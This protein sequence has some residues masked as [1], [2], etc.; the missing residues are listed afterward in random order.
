M[1]QL[2]SAKQ[3]TITPEIKAVVKAEGLEPETVR[4]RIAAGRAVIPAN[5]NR[6]AAGL[7]GIGEGLRTKVNANI[8][9]SVDFADLG[10]ELEKLRAAEEAGA[11]AV[12]D[13]STGGDLTAI[14]R[15]I[16]E[17]SSVSV[18]TVPIYEATCAVMRRSHRL[19]EM[20]AAEVLGT[21]RKHAEDGVDFVVAHAAINREVV[22]EYRSSKR[23]CGIVSRGGTFLAQ[24]MI[25]TGEENPLYERYDDLLDMA[26]EYDVTLSLGDSMR[27][28]AIADA[29]DSLQ[30]HELMIQGEL[31][32]RALD[33]GVQVMIEGPGHV[34]LNQVKAQME[35]EKALCHG[36][37]F[38]VLGPVVT[39]V[40]IGYDHITAAIGGAVAA[41]SGADFLCYVTP[42]E[43]VGLPSP[44]QV[45]EG[46]I[47]AR[48]AAHAG[49]I[50]KGI[51]GAQ[52]WDRR[53][54]ELRRGRKW[55]EQIK[56]SMDPKRAARLREEAAPH[57]ES[58]CS[59]CGEYCV[60]KMA[61]LGAQIP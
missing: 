41:A 55:A 45:R 12:M 32:K 19:K 58:V 47:A 10:V 22:R 20:T 57:D 5:V 61:D 6:R 51:P 44:E 26:R 3:G 48:I 40:A 59:M 37:P 27:P 50:A 8:G 25:Q 18:G 36:A 56:A 17:R 9:T 7:V 30:V 42:S 1:T 24:W 34:P 46:V 39:D 14:R 49:D 54:S 33:R 13:L 16:M 53:L 2:E 15:A 23:V 31:A 21:F 29:F 28:G 11:D 60:F 43:H 38:Y 35:L 52:D 4:A